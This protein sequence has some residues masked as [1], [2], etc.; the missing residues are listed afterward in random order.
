[1]TAIALWSVGRIPAFLFCPAFRVDRY[2]IV[3]TLS[4]FS[5]CEMSTS[6]GLLRAKTSF[7]NAGEVVEVGELCLEGLV[8]LRP[9]RSN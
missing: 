9:S 3:A 2:F 6:R 8:G 5:D 1:M 4:P 7:A